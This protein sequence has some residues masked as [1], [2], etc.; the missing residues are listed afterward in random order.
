MELIF[1]KALYLKTCFSLFPNF[2]EI[3]AGVQLADVHSIQAPAHLT[4]PNDLPLNIKN[5]ILVSVQVFQFYI[6]KS[7]SR[8]R[9]DPVDKGQLP[10]PKVIGRSS[11][12]RLV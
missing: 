8:I 11:Q 7:V 6:Q 4:F 12:R 10:A 3:L 9:K 1:D 2:Q 5:P